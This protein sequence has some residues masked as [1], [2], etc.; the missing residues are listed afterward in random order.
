[1]VVEQVLGMGDKYSGNQYVTS[2]ELAEL[3]YEDDEIH[4][5]ANTPGNYRIAVAAIDSNGETE[6]N[7]DVPVFWPAGENPFRI[8]GIALDTWGPPD[9]NELHYVERLIDIAHDYGANF[10]QLAPYWHAG[11]SVNGSDIQPCSDIPGRSCTTP[12]DS[13]IRDWIRHAHS[14]GLSVLLKPHLVGGDF[15][16]DSVRYGFESWQIQ[17]S[18]PNA[19]F[20]SYSRFIMHYAHIAEEENVEI[21]S[22]GN[23]LNGTT[24]YISRWEN[25]IQE[26]ESIY[27]GLLTYSDVLLW[28][29]WQGQAWFWD[30]LDL[31][32]IP[33]YYN[34]SNNNAHPSIAEMV[35]N[36]QRVQRTN[37][38][39][40]MNSFDNPLLATEFGRPNFNGTNY[41]PWTWSSIVDNQELVD[42]VEA[43]FNTM[44]DLGPRFQGI[45]IWKLWPREQVFSVD[46]D[47]RGK[48]LAEAITYWFSN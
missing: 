28:Q 41:D 45:F 39:R 4:F 31:I 34:G 20:E 18:D 15:D 19:W 23:E 5:L 47:F 46:W 29:S 48:P 33:Y 10:I 22:A 36:I 24:A 26:I 43:G 14:L 12:R 42:Y 9:F 35:N 37:L 6:V 40:A 44:L 21:F 30:S 7:I 2:Q 13:D 8:R 17:P 1:M 38:S 16:R 11:T 3:T 27:S 32:G 25:Q